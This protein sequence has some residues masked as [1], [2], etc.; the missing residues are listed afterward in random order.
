M[1]VASRNKGTRQEARA[2]VVV[3]WGYRWCKDRR[4]KTLGN[5]DSVFLLLQ[6]D[7]CLE[8]NHSWLPKPFKLLFLPH[9]SVFLDY[10]NL[11]LQINIFK[12]FYEEVFLKGRRNS[13]Y[14][15]VL[16]I[17]SVV[18]N[19]NHLSKKIQ[20]RK[21][22]FPKLETAMGCSR[23][24]LRIHLP[25]QHQKYFCQRIK[26]VTIMPQCSPFILSFS[27]YMGQC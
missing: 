9:L 5:Q 11:W 6:E 14:H 10:T 19:G 12:T 26:N 15:N 27:F 22:F 21:I 23:Q 20:P 3:G 7:L 17:I 13:F 4:H 1:C 2:I 8:C 25:Q 24:N 18:L 16:F